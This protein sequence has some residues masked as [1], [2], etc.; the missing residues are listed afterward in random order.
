MSA[1]YPDDIDIFTLLARRWREWRFW[2]KARRAIEL[3]CDRRTVNIIRCVLAD[4][5]RIIVNRPI[6]M[7]DVTML[8]GDVTSSE[9]LGL[10]RRNSGQ[11]RA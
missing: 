7:P 5:E 4:E 6:E 8:I 3:E 9:V 11:R 10:R 1:S 2:R